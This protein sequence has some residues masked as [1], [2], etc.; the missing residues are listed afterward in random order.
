MAQLPDI[1][2]QSAAPIVVTENVVQADEGY[3]FTEQG[4]SKIG[5]LVQIHFRISSTNAITGRVRLGVINQ[6]YRPNRVIRGTAAAASSYDAEINSVAN[7]FILSNG[8]VYTDTI[9][10]LNAPKELNITAIWIV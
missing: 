10:G 6:G 7:F 3:T 4:F 2:Q 8:S 5:N 1:H 9:N